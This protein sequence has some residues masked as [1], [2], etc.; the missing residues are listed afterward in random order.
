MA[1]RLQLYAPK[2]IHRQ[3]AYNTS[4]KNDPMKTTHP[5]RPTKRGEEMEYEASSGLRHESRETP[6]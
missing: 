3:A 4:S 1:I 5:Q 2:S 6:P